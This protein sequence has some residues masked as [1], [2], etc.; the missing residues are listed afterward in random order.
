MRPLVLPC[1]LVPSEHRTRAPAHRQ[2]PPPHPSTAPAHLAATIALHCPCARPALPA[3]RPPFP[4]SASEAVQHDIACAE[5]LRAPLLPW[6]GPPPTSPSPP[7]VPS[8]CSNTCNYASDGECDDGGPGAEYG[9]CAYGTECEDCG[10]RIFSPPAPPPLKVPLPSP[11]PTPPTVPGCLNTCNYASDGDCDDGGPGA[12]YG[13]C[14]YGTECEDCGPRSF[15]P[16]VP[17]PSP[18][19]CAGCAAGEALAH[20]RV[21]LSVCVC[22]CWAASRSGQLPFSCP[23]CTSPLPAFAP[24]CPLQ[25]RPRTRRAASPSRL[26]HACSPRLLSASRH[27][28]P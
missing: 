23:A 28:Q 22:V 4:R 16:F 26:L 20:A 12:E 21:C 2:I 13:V 10:P 7:L 14:A 18:P 8:L 3:R 24:H 15:E 1:I 17:P 5:A 19:V 11:P 9:I 25:G 27:G 6:S